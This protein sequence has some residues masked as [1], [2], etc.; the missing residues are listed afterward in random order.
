MIALACRVGSVRSECH[1]LCV[2][3]VGDL[4][5]LKD[6]LPTHSNEFARGDMHVPYYL[7]LC[8]RWDLGDLNDKHMFSRYGIC[9]VSIFIDV[10]TSGI[11]MICT[12][13]TF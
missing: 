11:C 2:H 9:E 13:C 4:H 5:D 7:H 6:L 3:A 12:I 8:V 10:Y 1:V